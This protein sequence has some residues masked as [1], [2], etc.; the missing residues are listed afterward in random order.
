MVK[1][2]DIS[3]IDAIKLKFAAYI[4]KTKKENYYKII[5]VNFFVSLRLV[6]C[7]FSNNVPSCTTLC[8]FTLH[9]GDILK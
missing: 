5:V 8:T 2:M 1:N 6:E 9:L 4:V 7:S 3:N